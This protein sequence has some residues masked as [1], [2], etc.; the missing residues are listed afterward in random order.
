MDP[1]LGISGGYRQIG[2]AGGSGTR[3]GTGMRA[4]CASAWSVAAAPG[5]TTMR[6]VGTSPEQA[7][8]AAFWRGAA[9]HV[10][11]VVLSLVPA[12]EVDDLV[13]EVLLALAD[14][15]LPRGDSARLGY[16]ASTARNKCNDWH[17]ARA[18]RSGLS[19]ARADHD[20]LEQTSA[21]PACEAAP[22]PPG[23]HSTPP[24]PAPGCPHFEFPLPC[25]A[26]HVDRC[27]LDHCRRDFV[28]RVVEKLRPRQQRV[29]RAVF[30]GI[31][32]IK[33]IAREAGITP[34]DCREVLQVLPARIRKLLSL[35]P[36]D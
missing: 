3:T 21:E 33:A 25:I 4:P 34:S 6:A 16:A 18:R 10:R 13:Q 8:D 26:P 1:W 17:R 19:R 20:V 9:A 22:P 23:P 2:G 31:S 30:S 27:N 15:A 29:A 28:L 35:P 24:G 5:L 11:R 12:R 32:G 36:D 7:R 14:A